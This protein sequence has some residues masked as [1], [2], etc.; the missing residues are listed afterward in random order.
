MP[1]VLSMPRYK[2]PSYCHDCGTAYPWTES[3]LEAAKELA[4]ELDG[5]SAEEKEKLK[6]SLNDLVREGPRTKLAETRFKKIMMKA[7][8]EGLDAMKSILIDIVSETI[9][10]S[11]FGQ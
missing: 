1:G 8:K 2:P 10:K 5:I 11:L 9:K 6:E 3:M 4:D 7:G